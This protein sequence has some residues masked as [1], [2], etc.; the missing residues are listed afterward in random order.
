MTKRFFLKY[1]LI[2]LI[3]PT[4][5]ISFFP[6]KIIII[7]SLCSYPLLYLVWHNYYHLNDNELTSL[8]IIKLY[9]AINFIIFFRGVF[10]LSSEQDNIVMFG[11]RIF[12]TLLV[13]M[14]IFTVERKTFIPILKSIVIFA[15]P[16][17]LITYFFPS[18]SN[19]MSFHH[20]ISIVYLFLF[21][22]PFVNKKWRIA[23]ISLAIF[24]L[25][26]DL[27]RRSYSFNLIIATIILLTYYITSKH[28]FIKIAKTSF[29][30]LV[31]SPILFLTL[32]LTGIFNIFKIG[33][34][35]NALVIET[36]TNSRNSLD[37]SRTSIYLDVFKELS[38]KESFLI[39]LGGNGKTK[40][41]LTDLS[42]GDFDIIYKEGRRA[43]ESGMLN[44]FQWGGIISAFSYWLLLT[45]A[46]FN[47]IYKSKNGLLI[48]LGLFMAFKVLYSFIED[49]ISIQLTSFYLMFMI[50]ICYNK[51]LQLLYNNQLKIILSRV[52]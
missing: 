7:S 43:T 27:T 41:S 19:T 20:N 5:F 21:F 17:S 33:D 24:G 34:N 52:F 23:I 1:Q 4:I 48:M 42:Y 6:G 11:N 46:S 16:L 51:Y 44:Y 47:A 9:I 30:I 31:L 40:T 10:D 14:Y 50:G 35:F 13:P 39:G 12:T 18:I 37:D 29:F 25:T 2:L 38:E 36:K 3:I 32:G 22:I 49:P 8:N 28:I 15:I 45:A 26:Y